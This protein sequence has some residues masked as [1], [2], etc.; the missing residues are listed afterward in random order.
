[1][2]FDVYHSSLGMYTEGQYFL[3]PDPNWVSTRLTLR[4]WTYFF[5]FFFWDDFI[6]IVFFFLHGWFLNV[7][8][9]VMTTNLHCDL[10]SQK[11]KEIGA[12][13]TALQSLALAGLLTL[14]ALLQQSNTLHPL[15]SYY[16][17]APS[18]W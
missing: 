11:G 6:L 9:T 1:M 4:F 17:L 5:F 15:T 18:V 8:S 10:T 13:A 16:A 12:A 3:V 7:Y 2:G 14:L